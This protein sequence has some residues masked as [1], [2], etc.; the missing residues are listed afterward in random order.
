[1]LYFRSEPICALW[2]LH[3]ATFSMLPL[4]VLDHLVFPAIVLTFIYLMLIRITILWTT[5][6]KISVPIWDVLSLSTIS[7]N[8][9]LIGLFYLSTIVGCSLLLFGQLFVLPPKSLPF[10][11]PLLVSAYSC[12]HFVLFFVYFNFRQIFGG[13]S[14]KANTTQRVKSQSHKTKSVNKKR[15][16]ISVNIL[17]NKIVTKK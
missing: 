4:L 14:M 8:V 5:N 16:W 17:L 15:N 13:A 1:M 11:F 12:V 2:F 10:L 3:I 7:D 6:E 9:L